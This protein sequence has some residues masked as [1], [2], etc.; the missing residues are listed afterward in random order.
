MV[1]YVIL[2]GQLGTI[3]A[4]NLQLYPSTMNDCFK[5]HILEPVTLGDLVAKVKKGLAA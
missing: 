2:L 3:N 1:K 4:S 5:D